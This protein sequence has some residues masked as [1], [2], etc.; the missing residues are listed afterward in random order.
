MN[1]DPKADNEGTLNTLFT[2][3]IQQSVI[4]VNRHSFSNQNN[5]YKMVCKYE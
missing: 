5:L 2:F 1:Y 3:Q 4:Y